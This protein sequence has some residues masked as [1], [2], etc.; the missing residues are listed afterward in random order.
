MILLSGEGF[1]LRKDPMGDYTKVIGEPLGH[2]M[3]MEVYEFI[4]NPLLVVKVPTWCGLPNWREKALETCGRNQI[5]WRML[6][7]SQYSK[8]FA[9]IVGRGDNYILQMRVQH[10]EDPQKYREELV[11]YWLTDTKPRNFGILN[12]LFVCV[13]YA[14]DDVPLHI[15][16]HEVLHLKQLNWGN[17]AR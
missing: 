14:G 15:D 7:H 11:P 12:G 4:H 3:C 13:D 6:A 8:F 10:I 17:R 9:P 1:L 16:N 5:A 2:G